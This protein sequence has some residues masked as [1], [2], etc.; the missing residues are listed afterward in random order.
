VSRAPH[1]KLRKLLNPRFHG[2]QVKGFLAAMQ[3]AIR[4]GLDGLSR[5][6]ASGEALA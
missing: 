2:A 1:K 5:A 4:A 6:G 3:R